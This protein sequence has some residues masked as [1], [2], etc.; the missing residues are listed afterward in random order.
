MGV[1]GFD[2]FARSEA[3]ICKISI[4]SRDSKPKNARTGILILKVA[5]DEV[6]LNSYRVT[7]PVVVTEPTAYSLVA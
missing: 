4:L 7:R 1:Q 2:V 5:F 3:T 6:L